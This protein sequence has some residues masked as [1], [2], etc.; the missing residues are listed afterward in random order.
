VREEL[1]LRPLPCQIQRA[2][3]GRYIGGLEIGKDHRKV[4]GERSCE[5]PSSLTIHHDLL[6]AVLIPNGGRLL[7]VCCPEA[8]GLIFGTTS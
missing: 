4:P 6:T 7:P 8:A 3:A 5:G 2:R 1:N